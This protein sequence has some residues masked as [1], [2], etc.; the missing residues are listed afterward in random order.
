[1]FTYRKLEEVEDN[2]NISVDSFGEPFEKNN[3][4]E[5]NNNYWLYPFSYEV[6]DPVGKV[7][8]K[9]GDSSGDIIK[10]KYVDNN[11][12]NNNNIEP[13]IQIIINNDENTGSSSL[14]SKKNLKTKNILE[15]NNIPNFIN[16]EEKDKKEN[17]DKVPIGRKRKNCLR[18]NAFHNKESDDNLVRKIKHTIIDSLFKFLNKTLKVD[19]IFADSI[20]TCD[21]KKEFLKMEQG[22]IV[23][24][25]ADYNRYFLR[26]KVKDIFSHKISTKF[27]KYSPFHNIN[28]INYLL[29]EKRIQLKEKYTKIFNLTFL[30]CLEYFRGSKEIMELEGMVT[31]SQLCKTLVQNESPEYVKKFIEYLIYFEQIIDIKK[32]RKRKK[33]NE[34]LKN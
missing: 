11:F 24:S 13:Q 23:S 5:I 14:I 17:V 31:F 15:D 27:K 1:M 21:H 16:I 26:K 3:E 28:L 29:D 10:E 25:K 19:Y 8:E 32:T 18:T 33:K 6:P 2:L 4:N 9:Q 34:Q 30:D 20:E 22:Q 7:L 12:N